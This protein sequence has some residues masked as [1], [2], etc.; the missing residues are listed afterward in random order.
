MQNSPF[1]DTIAGKEAELISWLVFGCSYL[2]LVCVCA[3]VFCLG[4][5]VPAPES[6][7]RRSCCPNTYHDS[8]HN[9][10]SNSNRKIAIAIAIAIVTVIGFLVRSERAGRHSGQGR[11]PVYMLFNYGKTMLRQC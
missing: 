6:A 1:C 5:S 3:R 10:D 9:S 11:E 4:G 8:R 2:N 7:R